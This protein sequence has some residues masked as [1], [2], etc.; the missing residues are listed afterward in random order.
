MP[1]FVLRAG[2][3]RVGVLAVEVAHGGRAPVHLF[4]L[5]GAHEYVG[6]R[7]RVAGAVGDHPALRLVVFRGAASF[8][9]P[10][11]SCAEDRVARQVFVELAVVGIA[12]LGTHTTGIDELQ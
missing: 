9:G 4:V 2:D 3:V 10:I 5:P 11:L 1:E 6:R 7:V 12:L 8:R